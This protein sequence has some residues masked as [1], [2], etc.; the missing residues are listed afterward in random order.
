MRKLPQEEEAVEETIQLPSAYN[1]KPKQ[2]LKANGE[3][4]HPRDKESAR[5]RNQE[6][7]QC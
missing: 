1:P 3:K 4:Q 7:L 2:V 5:Q 6:T